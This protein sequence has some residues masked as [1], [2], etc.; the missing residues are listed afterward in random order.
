MNSKNNLFVRY[1]HDGNAGFGPALTFGDPSNWP[2]NVNWADQSIL[3]L[4][5]IFTPTLIND[6]RFQYNYWNNHNLPAVSSDCSGP[7]VAGTFPTSSSSL[8]PIC[9]PSVQ[10]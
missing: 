5:T 4:T 7:C 6:L 3:G 10:I 9:R 8:A 1:S 2:H